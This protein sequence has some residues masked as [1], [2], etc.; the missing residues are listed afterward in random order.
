MDVGVQDPTNLNLLESLDVLDVPD[1]NMTE[2]PATSIN[3]PEVS[4]VAQPTP[5][6][7]PPVAPPVATPAIPQPQVPSVAPVAPEV[8]LSPELKSGYSALVDD[9]FDNIL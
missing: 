2:V 9:K 3:Q 7:A 8:G 6:V 1:I 5:L 4:I